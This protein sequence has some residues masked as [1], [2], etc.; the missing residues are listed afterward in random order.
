MS[1]KQ[2]EILSTIHQIAETIE[3]VVGVAAWQVAENSKVEPVSLKADQWYPTASTI[4]VP[5]LYE[6]YRQAEAG[7]IDLNQRVIVREQDFVPGSGILQDMA[8]ALNPTVRDLAVLMTVVSDNTA[9]DMLLERLGRAQV[10]KTMQELGLTQTRANLSLRQMLYSLAGLDVNNPAHT[11]QLCRAR[12]QD[13]TYKTDPAC[14]A[15][16]ESDNDLSSPNDLARLL[17]L[18]ARHQTLS[19]KSCEDM[20]DILSRQKYNQIIPLHLPS[21]L[22]VAHKTGS[23]NGVRN[24][25][26]LVYAP[27]GPYV[28]AL[29]TRQLKDEVAASEK[30]ARISEAVYQYFTEAEA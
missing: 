1:T 27:N 23:I 21:Y 13:P 26:G 15:L 10:E 6:L 29:M 18:I 11:Y 12:F 8:L 28:L 7:L 9:T 22:K 19:Q 25:V 2:A 17:S 24:D 4:K 14:Q 20:L 30:L 5:V 3:G 16:G